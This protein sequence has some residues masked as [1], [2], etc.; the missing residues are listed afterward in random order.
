VARTSDSQ[1][2]GILTNDLLILVLSKYPELRLI[3]EQT[4]RELKWR[5]DQNPYSNR[6]SMLKRVPSNE[7]IYGLLISSAISFIW[8][9]AKLE[10]D[11]LTERK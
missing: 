8:N 2:S 5:D 4:T 1:I 9:K 3:A 6:P 10:L 7:Q 11:A